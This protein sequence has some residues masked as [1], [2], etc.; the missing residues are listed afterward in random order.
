MWGLLPDKVGRGL[1]APNPKPETCVRR[2]HRRD[3]PFMGKDVGA[4]STPNP[5]PGTRSLDPSCGTRGSQET[6]SAPLELSVIYHRSWAA[7]GAGLGCAK[8]TWK[9][10]KSSGESSFSP[11]DFLCFP[12]PRSSHPFPHQTG[13]HC[14]FFRMA[15]SPALDAR[16]EIPCRRVS[17]AAEAP[18]VPSDNVQ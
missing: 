15:A 1:P 16:D 14:L 2:L 11:E 13:V 7:S 8:R 6:Y 18:D 17:G 12:L 3:S 9:T 10:G 5:E 4:S